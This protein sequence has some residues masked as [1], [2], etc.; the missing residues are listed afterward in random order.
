ML[1]DHTGLEIAFPSRPSECNS[2]KKG[3]TV[4][5][6]VPALAA[7]IWVLV[8]GSILSWHTPHVPEWI[9]SKADPLG[10]HLKNDSILQFH[11]PLLAR[12]QEISTKHIMNI[13]KI[14]YFPVHIRGWIPGAALLFLTL[15][16]MVEL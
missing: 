7:Q 2:A 3:G 12:N 4:L 13:Y 16:C 1:R 15:M 14:R 11:F 6:I 9:C 8:W 10:F 5:C